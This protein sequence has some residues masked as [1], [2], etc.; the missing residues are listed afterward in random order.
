MLHFAYGSN[1]HRVVMRKHAPKAVPVGVAT[2]ADYRFIIT[3]D[4]YASVAPEPGHHVCGLVWRITPHDRTTLDAWES[5]EA[6]LYR[7]EILPVRQAGRDGPALVY[8]A[9]A[10]P[11]GR[12]RAGYMEIVIEAAR[13]LELPADYIASLEEWLPKDPAG[14]GQPK[15]GEF[16]P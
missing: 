16:R 14:A 1:M 7:A 10:C 5:V 8:V 15:F 11:V 4:G 9:R 13:A 6:G 3:A 2:L 12:P